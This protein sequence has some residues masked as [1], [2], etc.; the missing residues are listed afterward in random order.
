MW[1]WSRVCCLEMGVWL[2]RVWWCGSDWFRCGRGLW[3]KESSLELCDWIGNRKTRAWEV[4][5]R[6]IMKGLFSQV[7]RH[8]NMW[9]HSCC[10]STTRHQENVIYIFRKKTVK[11]ISL[12]FFCTFPYFLGFFFGF[13]RSRL[14]RASRARRHSCVIVAGYDR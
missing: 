12:Y 11:P 9:L 10:L 5:G 7:R 6:N 4:S 3:S 8:K 14:L 13:L 1:M 2:S